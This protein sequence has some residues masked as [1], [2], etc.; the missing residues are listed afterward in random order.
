MTKGQ[1]F[2]VKSFVPY[3]NAYSADCEHPRGGVSCLISENFMQHLVSVS[4]DTANFIKLVVSGNHTLF[5][6]YLPPVDSIY[7]T[8]DCFAGI[9]NV[10]VPLES[11]DAVIGGGD[12]HGRFGNLTKIP[13]AG[14][15][16]RHNPDKEINSHGKTLKSI[17]SSYNCFILNN[18]SLPNR[19][20]DGNFTFRKGDRTSQA[21]VCFSNHTAIDFIASVEVIE[22]GSNPS[23]HY[24]IA[25]MCTLPV[26]HPN[27]A[28]DASQDLNTDINLFKLNK[29]KRLKDYLV[30][31]E[32]YSAIT[33]TD[34]QH[35][36]EQ[37][38]E[39]DSQESFN[40]FVDVS[41]KLYNKLC[42]KSSTC[43]PQHGPAATNTR[44]SELNQN[45]D[46]I[47]RQFLMG[48]KNS[49]DWLTAREIAVK[50]M[51]FN[52]TQAELDRWKLIIE[53]KNSKE[54]WQK[55]DWKGEVNQSNISDDLPSL[56]SLANQFMSKS[57]N[58][59]GDEDFIDVDAL[60]KPIDV[61]EVHEGCRHLKAS[62]ATFDGWS[63]NMITR[64][65]D[66][67]ISSD[68]FYLQFYTI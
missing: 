49:A 40:T 54:L 61:N 11:E 21:G 14:A 53:S 60:D 9:S 17:S 52:L 36:Y 5:G 57:S 43:D 15:K 20:F 29:P 59:N 24:P 7:F 34:M 66:V 50:E 51:S 47:Y 1:K 2:S 42:Y 67:F 65:S 64:C 41:K 63:P 8:E 25:V 4:S 30:N 48:E 19:H 23:D 46:V 35:F 58:P 33:E 68:Y 56:Q 22:L 18:L 28:R 16:Y 13:M 37:S 6:N 32:N 45:A 27:L 3:H 44:G 26:R 10:F 12:L 31:W 38:F 39:V 62:K 55:I